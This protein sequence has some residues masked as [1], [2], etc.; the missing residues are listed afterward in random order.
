MKAQKIY[1]LWRKSFGEN[2]LLG[3]Y[4]DPKSAKFEAL[5]RAKAYGLENIQEHQSGAVSGEMH[6]DRG[7]DTFT[8]FVS[9]EALL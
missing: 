5:K 6:T 2:S 1:I 9:T 4:R 7:V 8:F 3:V